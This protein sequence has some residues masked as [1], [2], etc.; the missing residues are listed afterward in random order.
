M[1]SLVLLQTRL[2]QAE[3][4]YHDIMTGTAVRRFVDQNG[5]QVEYSRAN[6]AQLSAYIEKL[7]AQIAEADGSTPAYRGPLRFTYGTP[8]RFR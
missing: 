5:E 2:E 1:V 6:V 7:R 8:R 3:S 4:A